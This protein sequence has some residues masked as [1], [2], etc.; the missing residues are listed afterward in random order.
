MSSEITIKI[1]LP[2]QQLSGGLVAT[3]EGVT[4]T[5]TQVGGPPPEEVSGG[6][7]AAGAGGTRCCVACS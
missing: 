1:T 3:A 6:V 2:D 5:A 4:E 7:E